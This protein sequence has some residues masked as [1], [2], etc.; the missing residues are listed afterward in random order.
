LGPHKHQAKIPKVDSLGRD[1]WPVHA[2][3]K[4]S[5]FLEQCPATKTLDS[6]RQEALDSPVKRGEPG[7]SFSIQKKPGIGN[8]GV[9][10]PNKCSILSAE[11]AKVSRTPRNLLH[12]F[13]HGELCRWKPK[14]FKA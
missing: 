12:F 8:V 4:R 13:G 14:N 2:F 3:P 5:D 1:T 9:H 11:Q 10:H 6:I 7:I